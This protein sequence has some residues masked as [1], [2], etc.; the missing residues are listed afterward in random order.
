MEPAR[1][2]DAS[3]K[4][5]IV[6]MTYKFALRIIRMYQYLSASPKQKELT[7]LRQVLRSGTSIGANVEEAQHAQSLADFLSKMSISLKETRETRYWLRL[8][9]DSDYLQENIADSMLAD[10][11]DIYNVLKAI[12]NTSSQNAKA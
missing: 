1:I 3:S 8:L 4:A 6:S 5:D 7:L 11:E 2:L 10:C 12:V 9:K